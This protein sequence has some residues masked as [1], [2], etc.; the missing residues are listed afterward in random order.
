[1][2]QI[3]TGAFGTLSMMAL[4]FVFQCA[5]AVH[6]VYQLGRVQ[7]HGLVAM[8]R[9]ILQYLLLVF[10]NDPRCLERLPLGLLNLE[11]H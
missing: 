9:R 5:L 2:Q 10:C 8:E 1:M 7:V 4:A 3:L 11:G 6:I